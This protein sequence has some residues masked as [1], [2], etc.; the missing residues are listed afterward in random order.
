LVFLAGGILDDAA[1]Y[2]AKDSFARGVGAR[3]G[4]TGAGVCSAEVI[5]IGPKSTG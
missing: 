5:G 2:G 4:A 1:G 3:D